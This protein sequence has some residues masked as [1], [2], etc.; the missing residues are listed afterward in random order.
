MAINPVE[1][2]VLIQDNTRQGLKGVSDGLDGVE[3]DASAA[4]RRIKELE[5]AIARIKSEA[6][7]SSTADTEAYARQIDALKRK[8]EELREAANKNRITPK[9]APKA[10]STFNGLNVSIQQIARELPSLAMGPQMFFL[11]ISNNLPIFTDQ[12]SKARKEYQ[13]LVAAGQKGTPVWKQVLSSIVSWQTALA[14][15]IMLSVTYGKEIGEWIKGLAGAKKAFD[16]AKKAAEGFHAALTQGAANAQKELTTLGLLYKAA[17]DTTKSYDER[18]AA[19][20]KLQSLYPSYFDNLSNETIMAGK[21]IDQY[22]RLRDA[23]LETAKAR[24]AEGVIAENQK[25]LTLLE[26]TGES[27]KKYKSSIVDAEKAQRMF[28]SVQATEAV[29]ITSTRGPSSTFTELSS[30]NREAQAALKDARKAFFSELE[31]LGEDGKELTNRLKKEYDGNVVQFEEYINQL[32]DQLLPVAEK[33]YIDPKDAAA[34]AKKQQQEA[35]RLA[36]EAAAAARKAAAEERKKQTRE[37]L[38]NQYTDALLKQN[39]E[40]DELLV[41]TQE[42]GLEKELS[43][44]RARRKKRVEEYEKQEREILNL[45]KR[46]RDAGKDLG[47]DAEQAVM[48]K[49]ALKISVAK[50]VETRELADAE[51]AYYDKFLSQ[52][53]SYL[54]GIERITSKYDKD[55][56]K[57]TDKDR[58][59]AAERAKKKALEEFTLSYAKQFPDFEAWADRVTA[60]SVNKLKELL[61]KTREELKKLQQDPAADQNAVAKLE[62]K[63]VTIEKLIPKA[64]LKITDTKRWSDLNSILSS[65]IDTFNEVGDTIGGSTGEVIAAIGATAGATL[66]LVNNLKAFREASRTSDTLGKATAVLGMISAAVSAVGML[67]K[68]LGDGESS[69]ER[70]LRLAREFNEELRVARLRAQIDSDEFSTIFG[71][72]LFSQYLQN[73]NAA[74][75]ALDSFADAKKRIL[76]RRE[77]TFGAAEIK[78][79]RD[80]FFGIFDGKSFDGIDYLRQLYEFPQYKSVADSIRNMRVQTQHKTAFRNAKYSTLGELLPNLFN[81]DEVD[82]EA[83][84]KFVDEGGKTFEHLSG[85]HQEMLKRMVEDWESYEEAMASVRSYLSGI[86]GDLG[87]QLTDALVSSFETGTDA[88]ADFRASVGSMLRELAKSMVYSLNFGKIFEEAQKKVEKLYESDADDDTKFRQWVEIMNGLVDDAL[89]QQEAAKRQWE[90]FLR[91]AKEKGLSIEDVDTVAQAGKSGALQTVTQDSFS[92]VEGLVTSIQIHAANI[93]DDFQGTTITLSQSLA[94]L[95]KISANTE[96]LPLILTLLYELRRDGLKIK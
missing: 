82:M 78:A 15:G 42:E 34:A 35:E 17:T 3:K 67:A 68:A 41:A 39:Q 86:F 5:E 74:R 51:K 28:K 21:A 27:Y 54:Q 61:Q 91:L 66:Q 96:S 87:N 92:R 75:E 70:N 1:I 76:S 29:R 81:G 13:A 69:L 62:A 73:V 6:A 88:A 11:S 30:R 49:T 90:E 2:E 4:T 53:E 84:K 16:A 9:D 79:I 48:A 94:E 47:P 14:V 59:E 93:D 38:E 31:K 80:S 8:L 65:V 12:L 71:D 50:Q 57:L 85:E 89:G 43:A 20:A 52:Y 55:I 83:L 72:R 36:R 56:A 63:I 40:Y 64:E 23:I 19:V 37:T 10:M 60:M 25:L 58:R 46:L 45:I 32:N 22:N 44:I 18:T 95:Q 33:I 77:M 24:A 26:A 7:K